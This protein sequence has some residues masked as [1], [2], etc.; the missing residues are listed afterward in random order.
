MAHGGGAQERSSALPSPPRPARSVHDGGFMALCAD[1][2]S[3]AAATDFVDCPSDPG[4]DEHTLETFVSGGRKP[5]EVVSVFDELKLHQ[6]AANHAA[7][8]YP[9]PTS[10][11]ASSD[12]YSLSAIPTLNET[13]FPVMISHFH[14]LPALNSYL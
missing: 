1:L 6:A 14:L 12:P 10:G 4:F 3:A 2:D 5:D 11:F 8:E 9:M 13:T 7:T